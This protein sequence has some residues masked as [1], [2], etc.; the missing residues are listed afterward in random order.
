MKLLTLKIVSSTGQVKLESL[1]QLAKG[2]QLQAELGRGQCAAGFWDSGQI[3]E[4]LWLLFSLWMEALM[5]S[6]DPEWFPQEER[7]TTDTELAASHRILPQNTQ[8]IHNFLLFPM[9][10]PFLFSPE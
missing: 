1:H 5:D 6:H 10:L 3:L 2:L 7:G 4:F 8:E 9:R